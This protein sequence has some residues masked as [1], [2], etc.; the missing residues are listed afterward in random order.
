MLG[1]VL[2][3]LDKAA[4]EA[5]VGP[6]RVVQIVLGRPYG[7]DDVVA[8]VKQ[9]LAHARDGH[10]QDGHGQDGHGQDGHGQDTRAQ[11][12]ESGRQST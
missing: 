8:A 3:T 12:A 4:L 7:L 1:W 2:T 10:G 9:S 6:T 5:A 11:D